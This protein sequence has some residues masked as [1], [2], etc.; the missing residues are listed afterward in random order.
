MG[1]GC[2]TRRPRRAR[3]AGRVARWVAHLLLAL[4]GF[5]VGRTRARFGT[6]ASRPAV[7][8]QIEQGKF[9]THSG[10]MTIVARMLRERGGGT[11]TA[12]EYL[13][14]CGTIGGHKNY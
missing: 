8:V 10:K 14:E 12:F 5:S 6:A 2:R 11:M 1:K 9:G 3:A 13:S 7:A 4:R